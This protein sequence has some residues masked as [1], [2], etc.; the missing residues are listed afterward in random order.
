MMLHEFRIFL[1]NVPDA[2]ECLLRLESASETE[3][4]VCPVSS[5]WE[6]SSSA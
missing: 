3:A 4:Q 2:R 6:A 5:S 1:Q